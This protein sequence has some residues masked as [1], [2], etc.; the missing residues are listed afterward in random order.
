[1]NP[2]CH[3]INSDILFTYK[4]FL[5]LYVPCHVV[6]VPTSSM[7]TID[8]LYEHTKGLFILDLLMNTVVLVFSYYSD[9]HNL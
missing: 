6:T 3:L 1:M 9:C 7:M 5:P 4:G 2:L 8:P